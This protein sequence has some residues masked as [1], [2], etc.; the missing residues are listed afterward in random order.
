MSD[1]R[2]E[3]T[4]L[5]IQLSVRSQVAPLAGQ[6]TN[7]NPGPRGRPASALIDERA[8]RPMPVMISEVN[9]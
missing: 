4:F 6:P 8:A 5:K 2:C 1:T 7:L 9:C 3:L